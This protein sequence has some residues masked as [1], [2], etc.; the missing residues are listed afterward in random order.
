M[1]RQLL[2]PEPAGAGIQVRLRSPVPA[3]VWPRPAPL[4]GSDLPLSAGVP[5]ILRDRKSSGLW[6]LAAGISAAC[7]WRRFIRGASHTRVG[8]F[9][10]NDGAAASVWSKRRRKMN[11]TRC[12]LANSRPVLV[13]AACRRLVDAGHT[14]A[15]SVWAGPAVA[16]RDWL[17]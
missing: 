1:A 17:L 5:L 10:C 11:L 6:E 15:F 9:T 3:P 12:F 16:L 2:R 7:R 8:S 14:S 13:T 4:L